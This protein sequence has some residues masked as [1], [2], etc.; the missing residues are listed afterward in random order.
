MDEFLSAYAGVTRVT[1][2]DPARGFW[3]DLY[4]YVSQGGKEASERALQGVAL[5][6]GKVKPTPDVTRSRQLLVLAH[7][8][9]WNLTEADGS[10]WPVTLAS[11]RRLPDVVFADLLAKV[12]KLG[13][14][15][16]GER[17]QFPGE[18][19]GGD[20][21]GDGGAAEPVDVPAG[22]GDLEAARA[23]A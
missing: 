1:L 11:V 8:K 22:V 19:V 7:I 2:G 3:A 16:P 4:D 20:P 6:D 17:R 12:E 10:I 9:E 21:D 14:P 5:E 23:A 13:A 15:E 18:G